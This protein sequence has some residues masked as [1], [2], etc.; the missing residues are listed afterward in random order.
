MIRR[1]FFCGGSHYYDISLFWAKISSP[2]LLHSTTLVFT[3]RNP[4]ISLG[5][6]THA[7][8]KVD[9]NSEEKKT[10]RPNSKSDRTIIGVREI[11]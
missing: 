4:V 11:N 10:N 5:S 1:L 2:L 9:N 6:H 7:N 3:P 8:S